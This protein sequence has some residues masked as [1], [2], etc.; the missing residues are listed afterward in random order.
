MTAS[1]LQKTHCAW[2]GK[3]IHAKP[4]H[5][6][7]SARCINRLDEQLKIEDRQIGEELIEETKRH[8]KQRSDSWE[9]QTWGI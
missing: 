1:T 9:P 8:E 6:V 3:P 7:C 4:D 5:E 2:C